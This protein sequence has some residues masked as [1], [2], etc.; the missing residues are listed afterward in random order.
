[1]VTGFSA[2]LPQIQHLNPTARSFPYSGQRHRSIAHDTGTSLQIEGLQGHGRDNHGNLCSPGRRCR[3][4]DHP[5]SLRDWVDNRSFALGAMSE[6]DRDDRLPEALRTSRQ[7]SCGSLDGIGT[8]PP[9]LGELEQGCKAHALQ[10]AMGRGSNLGHL[11]VCPNPETSMR[12]WA[13]DHCNSARGEGRNCWTRCLRERPSGRP[14]FV[15]IRVR[16]NEQ[17]NLRWKPT[18]RDPTKW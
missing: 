12:S 2:P 11:K 14:L 6:R 1:M 7:R 3:P 4:K 15:K 17:G 9:G 5:G 10:G 8:P 13:L 18:V 16:R